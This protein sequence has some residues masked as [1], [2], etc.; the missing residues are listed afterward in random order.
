MLRW[1]CLLICT[2]G[3]I[4]M[5]AI[6]YAQDGGSGPYPAIIE[7]DPGVPGHTIY[8][9][10]NLSPF[11]QENPMPVMA[12]GNGGCANS[13]RMHANFLE[14]IASHG[15][16]VV[17]IGPFT[18]EAKPKSGGMAGGM[19][20]TTKSA[21]LLEA[22]DWAT[23][24]NNLRR[25]DRSVLRHPSGSCFAVAMAVCTSSNEANASSATITAPLSA[26]APVCDESVSCWI[27]RSS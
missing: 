3:I 21:Q 15:F 10:E 11:S 23:A 14:E 25:K 18:P 22:L 17:A 27:R 12:W 2:F 26:R 6:A 19:G 5:A 13:S 8:R 16:L 7:G 1:V 24:E 9:P 20:G 4:A